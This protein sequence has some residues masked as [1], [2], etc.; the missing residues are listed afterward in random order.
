MK[1]L[2][3]RGGATLMGLIVLLGAPGCGSDHED[4]TFLAGEGSSGN[5][6]L[7]M[8]AGGDIYVASVRYSGTNASGVV[9]A[10]DSVEW[11]PAPE[12]SVQLALPAGV[13][14]TIT[15]RAVTGDGIECQGSAVFFV[16]A[17]VTQRVV[18]D[19]LCDGEALVA[20]EL[21]TP[22]SKVISH[23]RRRR[24]PRWPTTPRALTEPW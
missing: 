7:A 17:G 12:V 19:L 22:C 20:E 21:E 13:T 14:Y 15:L 1:N 4:R 6:R 16:E 9:V 11:E 2:Q 10:S 24:A 5:V 23:R 18:V 8:L 3:V